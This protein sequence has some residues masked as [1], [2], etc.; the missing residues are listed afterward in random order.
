MLNRLGVVTQVLD[1]A[2]IKRRYP[3]I[4]TDDLAVGTFGPDDGPFD[5]HMI[6]WGYARR[7]V[8]LGGPAPAPGCA[9]H[10]HRGDGRALGWRPYHGRLHRHADRG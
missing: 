10:W 8:A 1:P 3:E 5:P 9:G 4:R 6:V 7:A 2:E